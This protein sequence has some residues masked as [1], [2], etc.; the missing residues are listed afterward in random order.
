MNGLF[1]QSMA[2]LHTWSG[3]VIGWVLYMM[4]LTGT[5]TFF[6]DEI[7]VWMRPELGRQ[8]E[9]V[10]AAL[11]AADRLQRVAPD[12]QSWTITVPD[13]RDPSTQISWRVA[14]VADSSATTSSVVQRAIL[15]SRTGEPVT[16]R[17][18]RG[19]E[20]FYRLHY[21]FDRPGRSAWGFSAAA[22][23]IMLLGIISGVIIHKRIF[24]DFFTFRP[25]A[26]R[27]RSWLDAHNVLAVIA[28]PFHVMITYTGLVPIMS[29]VMPSPIIANYADGRA[30]GEAYADYD[31]LRSAYST[32]RGASQ[33]QASRSNVEAPLASLGAIADQARERWD[34]GRIGSIVVTNPGDRTAAV[35]VVRHIGDQIS[36]R[37]ERLYFDGVTGTFLRS[38]QDQSA[39]EETR[40]VLYGLH[41][42][43]FAD[44]LL[45]WVLFLLGLVSTAMI[46]TGLIVW[47]VKRARLAEDP[48][49][50]SGHAIVSRLNVGTIA[51]LP[52]AMAGL[53]WANRLLPLD[54]A[55]RASAEVHIFFAIWVVAF[56]YAVVR[57]LKRAWTE[58]L[59]IASAAFAALPFVNAWTTERGFFTSL[60]NGDWIMAGFD[61]T[62]LVASVFFA[63]AAW[64][65][66]HRQ[67]SPVGASRT[68]A[69]GRVTELASS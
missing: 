44:P 8:S 31:T 7:S 53:F 60:H 42:G 4:F 52:I 11:L 29:T 34:G 21:R 14:D 47:T 68:E 1:R 67:P 18:T 57:P 30:V 45:R 69:T 59:A 39:T 58:E 63:V 35:E 15:D 5:A 19:G 28:L 56:V 3:L 20:F 40:A 13:D 16:V 48:S 2:W 25:H 12:A 38:S 24:R 54:V 41:L 65:T 26:T 23:M 43:R 33:A 51:G 36:N 64:M 50:W 32:D 17:E 9:Q 62:A 55:D 61:L 46:A 6:Q 27:H 37:P 49:A 10:A 66:A 22:A